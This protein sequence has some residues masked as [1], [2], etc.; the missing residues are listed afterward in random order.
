[1]RKCAQLQGVVLKIG[2]TGSTG[3]VGREIV[4]QARRAGWEILPISRRPSGVEGEL[5]VE[6][7]TDLSRRENAMPT[8]D[9]FIHLAAR[10]HVLVELVDDPETDYHRVNVEGT[11]AVLD[12]AINAGAKRF[13]FMSSVK[14]VGEWST[15]GD[16]LGPTTRPRPED[17]YGRTKLAAENLVREVCEAS[18]V[19]WTILRPPLVY[20]PGVKANLAR[21][22][23]AVARGWPLPLGSIDNRRSLVDVANLAQVALL[24]SVH[25]AAAG[26]ILMVADT[27]VSTSELLRE[28]GRAAGRPARLISVPRKAIALAARLLGKKAEVDRLICSLE[29]DAHETVECLQWAPQRGF[30]EGIAATVE[31]Q[32]GAGS[33]PPGM[34][35][36]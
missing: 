17:A 31:A 33:V 27:T 4:V 35:T 12:A 8:V 24:A 13:V 28:I 36:V 23:A 6:E 11:R 29:L 3:F 19:E 1:M 10:T 15:P 25:E 16:P 18:S 14:A 22:I 30:A 26:K 5:V 34:E 2:M 7:L 9:V 20:G 32:L 21:L